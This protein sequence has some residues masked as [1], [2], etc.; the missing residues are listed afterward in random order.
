MS[1][2]AVLG[3][4]D[5]QLGQFPGASLVK[6]IEQKPIAK[7]DDETLIMADVSRKAIAQVKVAA[8][9]LL[10]RHLPRRKRRGHWRRNRRPASGRTDYPIS[11]DEAKRLGLNVSTELPEEVLQLGDAVPAA[12]AYAGWQRR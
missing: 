11:P 4:V 3:P 9:E 8:Q 7:I 6:V 1:R 12:R 5:P 10:E 2:Y